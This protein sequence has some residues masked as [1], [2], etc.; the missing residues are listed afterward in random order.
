ML[1]LQDLLLRLVLRLLL[2]HLLL[3]L[4]LGQFQFLLLLFVQLFLYV[5]GRLPLARLIAPILLRN[6][7]R[8]HLTEVYFHRLA[9]ELDLVERLSGV[10]GGC[11]RAENDKGLSLHLDVSLGVYCDD[12]S[13]LAEDFLQGLLQVVD[14][15]FFVE[16]VDVESVLGAGLLALFV[17]FGGGLVCEVLARGASELRSLAWE[18]NLRLNLHRA[19]ALIRF[20]NS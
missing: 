16:V 14:L 7:V 5:H 9:V 19:G 10:D 2:Q 17:D 6:D 1:L 20:D 18:G 4:L 15:D 12:V 11:Q 3:L 8:L 13:V